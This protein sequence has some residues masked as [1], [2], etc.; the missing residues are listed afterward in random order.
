MLAGKTIIALV[1]FIIS[2]L[3]IMAIGVWAAWVAKAKVGACQSACQNAETSCSD[4]GECK[5]AKEQVG[6]ISGS[7][8]ALALLLGI[9]TVI[10][11]V[12]A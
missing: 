6:L 5:K 7:C 2:I 10:V 12:I 3:L 8:F 11:L 1:A 4:N 9:A